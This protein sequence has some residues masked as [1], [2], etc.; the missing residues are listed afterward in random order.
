MKAVCRKVW[1]HEQCC[2]SQVKT[3]TIPTL[4]EPNADSLAALLASLPLELRRS[5]AAFI[6]ACFQVCHSFQPQSPALVADTEEQ[7]RIYSNQLGVVSSHFS[8]P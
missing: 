7:T 4:E 2:H 6:C 5:M 3:V 8:H 1:R